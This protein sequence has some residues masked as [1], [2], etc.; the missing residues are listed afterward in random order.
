MLKTNECVGFS[1]ELYND[2]GMNVS[3]LWENKSDHKSITEG[4]SAQNNYNYT[5]GSVKDMTV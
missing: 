3:S 2:R 4:V 5:F 1:W